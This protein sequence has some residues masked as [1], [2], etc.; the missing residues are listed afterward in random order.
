MFFAFAFPLSF[1]FRRQM[2]SS[3]FLDRVVVVVVDAVVVDAVVVV[4]DAVIVVTD[5]VVAV[6]D[7]VIVFAAVANADI[8]NI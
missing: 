6:A 7:V 5:A 3:E 2:I 4:A 8:N 1:T